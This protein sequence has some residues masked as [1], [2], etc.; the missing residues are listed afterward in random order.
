MYGSPF[1]NQL[2]EEIYLEKVVYISWKR[3]EGK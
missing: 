3:R 2:N 1:I